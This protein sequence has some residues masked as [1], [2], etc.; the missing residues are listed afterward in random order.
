MHG[1]M[2]AGGK[3]RYLVLCKYPDLS[4]DSEC[5]IHES[6]SMQPSLAAPLA[7]LNFRAYT[8]TLGGCSETAALR[9]DPLYHN[10]DARDPSYHNADARDPPLFHSPH[11]KIPCEQA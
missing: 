5:C 7:R 8:Y 10:A 3:G 4:V 6:S 2:D 9:L 1:W 11:L